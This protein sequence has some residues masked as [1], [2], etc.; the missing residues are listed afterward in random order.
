MLTHSSGDLIA[1]RRYAIGQDFVLR[2]DLDAARDLFRQALE[3]AP[4]FAAAWFAL[5][6][7]DERSGDPAAAIAAF[8][9]VLRTDAADRL[10]AALRLARLDQ[11]DACDPMSPAY[12]RTLFDQY[13]AGFDQALVDDLDY[14]GPALL[15][16]AVGRAESARSRPLRFGRALDLGCGTGLAGAAF[17]DWCDSLV[18]I[19]VSPGMIEQAR[20]KGIYAEVIVGDILAELE[21]QSPESADLVIAADTLVYVGDLAA[22]C[23]AV[24][25][26]LMPQGLFAFTIESHAGSGIV[27]GD[28]LR[29]AHAPDH[30]RDALE[31]AGLT[32]IA[33]DPL[34]AR[35]EN[36]LPVPGLVAVAAR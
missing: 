34:S 18:G 11:E 22:M 1:D 31:A 30:A 25:R 23:R 12:V 21:G 32:V 20:R 6:E 19:D 4:G 15:R 24:A 7:T 5:G 16:E 33:L 2:G 10:G 9:Q 36:G 35:S 28:R 26:A 13:A 29:F 14:R 27:L 17:V 8:R 3:R